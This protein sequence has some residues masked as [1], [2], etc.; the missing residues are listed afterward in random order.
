MRNSFQGINYSLS[1]HQL[2]RKGGG[3]RPY[4][5]LATHNKMGAKSYQTQVVWTDE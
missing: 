2:I 3:N 5:T 1:L 4:E